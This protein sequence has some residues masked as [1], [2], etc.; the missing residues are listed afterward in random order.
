M[1][2]CVLSYC[3]LLYTYE[4]MLMLLVAHAIAGLHSREALIERGLLRY[5]HLTGRDAAA[6][7]DF[8]LALQEVL[9]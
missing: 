1:R 8:T 2:S 7:D 9:Y 6:A 5:T 4:Y 3:C